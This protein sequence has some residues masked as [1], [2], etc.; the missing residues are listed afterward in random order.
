M[1]QMR[2]VNES[3]LSGA[4]TSKPKELRRL[5]TDRKASTLKPA[6]PDHGLVIWVSDSKGDNPVKAIT[7]F[8]LRTGDVV[9]NIQI[10]SQTTAA[11]I[12][13]VCLQRLL[14]IS[15]SCSHVLLG[16]FR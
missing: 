4:K 1:A 13:K 15:H 8:I 11:D 16:P 10:T 6:R 5:L 9:S 3:R 7:S 12:L 2:Y 14:S